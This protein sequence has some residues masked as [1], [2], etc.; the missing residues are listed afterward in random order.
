MRVDFYQVGEATIESV[1][2]SVGQRLL[3][4]GQRLLVVADDEA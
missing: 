1:I 3:G 4:K 2:A